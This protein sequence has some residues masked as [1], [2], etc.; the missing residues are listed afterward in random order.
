MS[1]Q[2]E[3]STTTPPLPPDSSN[4][5]DYTTDS[6]STYV[7]TPGLTP[8]SPVHHRA[9]YH[10]VASSNGHDTAYYGPNGSPHQKESLEGQGLGI[11]N[12]DP[13]PSA[14]PTGKRSHDASVSN[15]FLLSTPSSQ[16]RKGYTGTEDPILEG[17]EGWEDN[18]SRADPHDAFVAGAD[19]ESLYK[20]ASA[21]VAQSNGPPEPWCKAKKKL[22]HSKGNWH[23]V[24][25]L[26]LSVYSTVLSGVWL[27]VAIAKL[28]FGRS[29]SN[30]GGLPPAIATS[31]T[32]AVA[33]T[34]ELS[35]VTVLVTFLGQVLSRRAL[36]IRSRG[37]TL[38]EMA[39]QSWIMQPGAILTQWK[40]VKYAGLTSLGAI[41]LV[42]AVTAMFY[43]TASES[44]VE[45][46]LT[47]GYF[48][49]RRIYGKVATS[50]ANEQYIEQS[51]ETPIS[52]LEDPIFGG[53]TCIALEYSG[54]AP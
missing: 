8:G 32:T 10:R 5:S 14:S 20:Q 52:G 26:I 3:P 45:P 42:G 11:R 18:V 46:K 47:M 2:R 40:N 39:T 31:L 23:S 28:R 36:A 37:I 22:L 15:T 6:T 35:F 12:L 51:C 29:I 33:K 38:A 34:I 54:Q 19:T 25:V 48:K 1:P 44:L 41:A 16:S 24:T 43:T 27:G 7:G 50:F 9:G 53:T 17:Q 30:A 49:H 4:F 13:L 21:P